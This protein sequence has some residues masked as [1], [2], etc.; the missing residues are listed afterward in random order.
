[1]QIDKVLI[2]LFN[3]SPIP[4]NLKTPKRL[5]EKGKL[6]NA[7]KIRII[8]EYT[9]HEV[10]MMCVKTKSFDEVLKEIFNQSPLP[11]N[12]KQP[13]QLFNKGKLG[14]NSKIRII[15]EFS[16]WKVDLSC[17]ELNELI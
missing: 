12:L 9:D 16:E 2:K 15:N 10:K 13:K 4:N 8:N 14:Y 11:N 7:S 1:M 17:Y 6:G 5:F 3:Q